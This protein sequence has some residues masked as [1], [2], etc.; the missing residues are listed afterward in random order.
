MKKEEIV[1][2]IQAWKKDKNIRLYSPFKYFK[3]LN[4][5]ELVITKLEEMYR[6]KN[7]KDVTKIKFKTD[8]GIKNTKRSPY[9]DIFE[10]RF[11]IPASSSFEVK[12]KKTGVPLDIIKRVFQKG[13]AAWKYGHRPGT[14]PVQWGN[15]RVD[16]FLVLGCA[17]FSGD[18]S[19]LKELHDRVQHTKKGKAFLSQKP[20]CPKSKLNM[21]KSRSNFPSFLTN[22]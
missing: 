20:S 3:G 12:A 2:I 4:T 1:A 8:Q 7:E 22:I 11:Q 21:Y 14:T 6:N 17:A 15:A 19:L 13:V 5:K 9:H 10:E 16:S 18:A